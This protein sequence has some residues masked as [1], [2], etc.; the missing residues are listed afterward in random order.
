MVQAPS[1]V[2]S[3]NL[4]LRISRRTF[5]VDQSGN[6]A[7]SEFEI[8]AIPAGSTPFNGGYTL[9]HL[10]TGFSYDA[11]GN[12]STTES[13]S[14]DEFTF[15]GLAP[16]VLNGGLA[17]VTAL[18]VFNPCWT[19]GWPGTTPPDFT[20]LIT[21][22][23]QMARHPYDLVVFAPI[24][25]LPD[26]VVPT[27]GTPQT[28]VATTAFA[29]S[30]TATV[31]DDFKD[32]ISGIPVTFT[33]P[34]SGASGTFPGGALTV[35]VTTDS[36]GTATA[37]AFT[38][39]GATGSYTVTASFLGATQPASF[40][41]TNAPLT[42]VT[43]QT[44]PPGLMVSLDGGGFVAAPLT[45]GLVPGFTHTIATM[46]PQATPGANY[47][48]QSWSDGQPISHTIAVP[49]SNVTYT[50]T[51]HAQY[52]LTTSASPSG[53]GTVIPASGSFFTA[54]TVVAISASPN[55]GFTFTGWSGPVANS[56]SVSTTVPINAPT[57]VT[58]NF[59]SVALTP[60]V[61]SV[62]NAEGQS[63]IIAPNTWVAIIG[64]NLAP[65]GDTRVWATA[66]FTNNTLPTALD[67]VSVTVNGKPAFVYYISPTQINILTPPD[68]LPGNPQVVVTNNK[69]VS[70]PFT[71]EAQLISPSFFVFNGGPYVA[72]VHA[73]GKLIGPT[74]LFPGSSTP[75]SPGETVLIFANGFGPTLTPV[76]SGAITQSGS[77]S[78]TPVV[79]IGGVT[80]TVQFAG[81]IF[82]GLFQFNV[83]IPANAPPGDQS[84]TAIYNGA[85]V[86]TGTLITILPASNQ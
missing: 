37:P 35:T 71:A 51:F 78:P 56:S 4:A 7:D 85:S 39:N 64:T 82:P 14:S 27:K 67:G 75:A 54:G 53:T 48:W 46:S 11:A 61:T 52:Q 81:L 32:P 10:S 9:S 24:A 80:A 28:T 72:A 83:V 36:T 68:A 84:I 30:L 26:V 6:L 62:I 1:F 77:L 59:S 16:Q 55:Q 65:V 66:D 8:A 43:L 17:V 58:A 29:T 76:V 49:T 5:I 69:A 47:T 21:C 45:V 42:P 57:T 73:S 40:A 12:V 19:S 38:A 41:L 2:L 34:A 3:K 86:Q 44:S 22:L 18:N 79:T 25:G 50:A 60:T 23:D 33:A 15:A 31:T 13:G 70:G 74:N 20:V 63:N